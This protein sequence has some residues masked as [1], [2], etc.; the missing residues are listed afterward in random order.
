LDTLKSEQ[1]TASWL[2]S[3]A[4]NIARQ[5]KRRGKF[6]G[7]FDAAQVREKP[8]EH[9]P[10]DVSAEVALLRE[11]LAKLPEK[12]RE[13]LTLPRGY[14]NALRRMPTSPLT[15]VAT[16]FILF[17]FFIAASRTSSGCEKHIVRR[18]KP[19]PSHRGVLISTCTKRLYARPSGK[20]LL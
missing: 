16:A 10:P 2:F 4:R 19:A 11:A 17:I 9:T 12:Q 13:A 15:L 1:A 5:R 20:A 6:W 8:S 3:I 7:A 18:L 14:K